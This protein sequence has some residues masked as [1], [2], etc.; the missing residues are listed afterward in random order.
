MSLRRVKWAAEEQ[1]GET[2]KQR[3]PS[4]P[5]R[6]LSNE[7]VVQIMKQ[8]ET[9]EEGSTAE[10]ESDQSDEQKAPEP[11]LIETNEAQENIIEDSS[12]QEL[13]TSEESEQVQPEETSESPDTDNQI[14]DETSEDSEGQENHGTSQI[15]VGHAVSFTHPGG[16]LTDFGSPQEAHQA[17]KRHRGKGDQLPGILRRTATP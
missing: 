1:E 16:Q 11:E 8:K 7:D 6:V 9:T 2:E 14:S 10:T 15:C 17:H 4:G 13:K 12:E 5:E 3:A